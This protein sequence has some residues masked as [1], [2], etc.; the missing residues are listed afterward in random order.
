MHKTSGFIK[1]RFSL[2]IRENLAINV[3]EAIPDI[4]RL[5]VNHRLHLNL[6]H[7]IAGVLPFVGCVCTAIMIHRDIDSLT[8]AND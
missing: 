1:L 6:Y 2:H 8:K 5:T 3:S 4:D 7:K